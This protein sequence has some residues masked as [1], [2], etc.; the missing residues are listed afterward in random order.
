MARERGGSRRGASVLVI[1]VLDD[2]N[3]IG[4]DQQRWHI[5]AD[6]CDVDEAD[7]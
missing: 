6:S 2:G 1:R 3:E 4:V 5:F 7:E